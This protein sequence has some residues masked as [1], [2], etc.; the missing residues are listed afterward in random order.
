ME[1]CNWEILRLFQIQCYFDTFCGYS[2]KEVISPLPNFVGSYH[3]NFDQHVQH[4]WYTSSN[5]TRAKLLICSV[6]KAIF[7]FLLLGEI[8]SGIHIL[9]YEVGKRIS[10]KWFYPLNLMNIIF[11]SIE[12]KRVRKNNIS[13]VGIQTIEYLWKTHCIGGFLL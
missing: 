7:P 5:I 6:V 11:F 10:Q 12:M 13:S 1:S 3:I 2:L 4:L 9:Q 8:V